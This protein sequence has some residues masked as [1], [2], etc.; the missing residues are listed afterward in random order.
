MLSSVRAQQKEAS[1]AI[2][3]AKQELARSR[4]EST[5]MRQRAR[6]ELAAA[7]AEAT[8][9]R[10]EAASVLQSAE[11]TSQ[12]SA[13]EDQPG[14]GLSPGRGRADAHLGPPTPHRC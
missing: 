8:T 4:D 1:E 14:A 13:R 5:V 3:A 7:E 10:E 6:D 12:Q 9:K 11:K 2:A